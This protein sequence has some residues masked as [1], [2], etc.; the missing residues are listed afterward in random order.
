MTNSSI[1][2]YNKAAALILGCLFL[3]LSGC[4]ASKGPFTPSGS[5][6]NP[7]RE[8][9][10]KAGQISLF[11]NLKGQDGPSLKMTIQSIEILGENNNWTSLP[12]EPIVAD[13][14]LIPGGQLF[15]G[16]TSLAS[17]N[18]S[19]L[20]FKTGDIKSSGTEPE[21]KVIEL[22]M[23]TPL[24]VTQGDSHSLFLTWDLFGTLAASGSGKPA[25][26][27]EPKLKNM[28]V[29]VAYTTCPD[30]NTVYMIC[31]NTNRVC[32]SLGVSGGPSYLISDPV[33]PTANLFALTENDMDIKRIG[34]A[35][36]RV[37]ATYH[38]SSLGKELQFT[39][40]PDGQWAYVVDR[41]RGN[42]L[43]IN[44]RSG[45]IDTR[46]RLGYG[47]SYILYLKEQGLLA[48]T[49]SLSQTVV[50]L[51]PQTLNQVRAIS[52]GSKPGGLMLFKSNLLYIA[53]AGSHS[54]MVYN[55]SLNKFQKRIP[56]DLSPR[57]I[58]NANGRIYV[59]NSTS[60]SISVL[61]PGQLGVSK[62]I[63]LNGTPLELA[64]SPHNKWLYVS[65][66]STQTID[67]IN[68]VNNKMVGK[69]SLGALPRGIAVLQ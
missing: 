41:K 6:E 7:A 54:V 24:Y 26:S 34:P 2:E 38:L 52:T 56:V 15:L 57:R 23:R 53:E 25:L 68:P 48:V 1:I 50:L 40:S 58:L 64:Y 65:N 51:D 4:V 11:L 47:P 5:H 61:M 33:A 30:I 67:I 18:Y 28:P 19:R 12:F 46:K 32:D 69:I 8:R 35:S 27:L 45:S 20:R 55:L 31:T 3:L 62:T 13:S 14:R 22:A 59:A 43:R 10:G 29:D 44:L 42:I 16:R 21:A 63:P 66:G 39:I 60:R 36:N 49:L 9:V 17:G 37:E